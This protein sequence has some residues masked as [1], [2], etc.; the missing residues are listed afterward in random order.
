M[1]KAA[2]ITLHLLRH[3]EVNMKHAEPGLLTL[4]SSYSLH[5]PIRQ[6]GQWYVVSFVPDYS[7]VSVMVFHHLPSLRALLALEL[8]LCA[9][10]YSWTCL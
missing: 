5:L 10:L 1:R 8:R 6:R 4:G 7:G 9:E 2:V 3:E